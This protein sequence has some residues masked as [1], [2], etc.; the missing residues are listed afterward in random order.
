M[1]LNETPAGERPHIT[2]FGRR[3]AGKSSLVNAVT[4][5][6]LSVVSD[7]K[8]TTTD[9]VKRA[10]E[11]LPAGPVVIIDTPG[12]D[13]EG[14][15]GKKRV[16]RTRQELSRTNVAVLV[17]DAMEGLSAEDRAWLHLFE[18]R[19]IPYITAFS[20]ADLIASVPEDAQGGLYVSAKT[21]LNIEFLK[22]QI[23]AAAIKC[24]SGRK[25]ISDLIHAGDTVV[26][27]IPIDGSA[28][29]GR[30]ILPQQ[31]T[32]REILDAHAQAVVCQPEELSQTL[33]CLASPPALVITDSQA[34][35]SV[36]QDTPRSVL[37]TSFS[38]LFAR[39]KG[40]LKTLV[41]GAKTLSALK[42]GDKV[43]IA[44]SC[45][46][47]RQCKDIGTVQLPALIKKF[48]GADVKFSF[49]SGAEFPDRLE[50]F[51]LV[52]HC[53]GCM[54]TETEMK[55]RLSHTKNCGIPI[56]NYGIALAHMNGI[57]ERSLE[58]FDAELE[59]DKKL[60]RG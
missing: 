30:L 33:S 55:N 17:A 59:Q 37:L 57:L 36:A 12:T 18:E 42:D 44:E 50:E 46:H 51:A 52:V 5:Q 41:R 38:I 35:H 60:P 45:T 8:G 21:G 24:G 20:K 49:A 23:A 54:I 22:K 25:I 10:M 6:E 9:P 13:D 27:V 48:S 31:Q 4:G 16:Q 7:V 32:L 14:E 40:N 3:N 58:P 1:T 47:H 34:F 56:V 39:Y 11:L 53:G 43:L 26:L 15:L 2:F 19:G 28:P 29:K